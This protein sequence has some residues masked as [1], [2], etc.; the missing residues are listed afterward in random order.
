MDKTI[1]IS[2]DRLYK[3]DENTPKIFENVFRYFLTVATKESLFT[4]NK[5]FYKQIDGVTV[6]SLLGPA[7]ANIALMV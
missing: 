4:F 7:L 1:D 2:I 5:K 3:D 6:G